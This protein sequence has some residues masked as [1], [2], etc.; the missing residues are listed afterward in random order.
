MNS[1][2]LFWIVLNCTISKNI[3]MIYSIIV[4]QQYFCHREF[5]YSVIVVLY[6]KWYT[7]KYCTRYSPDIIYSSRWSAMSGGTV[8]NHRHTLFLL[9]FKKNYVLYMHSSMIVVV[10]LYVD[11]FVQSEYSSNNVSCTYCIL[12]P[13]IIVLLH[14]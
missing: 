2:E 9:Y 6:I 8:R 1:S 11:G 3:L 7:L 14:I 4:V 12:L 13:T 10:L 5:P